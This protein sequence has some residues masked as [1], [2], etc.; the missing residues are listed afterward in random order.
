MSRPD[1]SRRRLVAASCAVAVCAA[2]A[3]ASTASGADLLPGITIPGL[4]TIPGTPTVPTPTTPAPP[5]IPA[6]PTETPIPGP[7]GLKAG[8]C[9]TRYVSARDLTAKQLPVSLTPAGALPNGAASDPV[10][11]RDSRANRY[12]AY[13]STATDIAVPVQAGRK[14]VYLAIRGGRVDPNANP[15]SLG[16]NQI[17][18][19]GP[20]G[21]AA[22]GDSWGAALSGTTGRNDKAIAARAMAFLSTATN[23]APG[24]NPTGTS[25][26]VRPVAG[27][28]I[29]RVKAPGV[30]TGVTV[31]GDSKVVWVTTDRGLFM[32]RDGK[33]RRIASGAGLSSPSTTVNG[34]QVAYERSGVV[35]TTT[36]EGR[37]RRIAVGS[38]PHADGGSADKGARA[39]MIRAIS[40]VR[41]GGAWRAETTGGPVLLKRFGTTQSLSSIN[42]GGNA[43]AFGN[44]AH[45]CIEV[46]LLDATQR[47]GGYSIPQG[48][49][50]SGQGTVTD[51]AVSTRY[52][53][54]AFTCSGGGLYLHYVGPK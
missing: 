19:V 3:G 47:R 1:R 28:A 50:P 43:V 33:V 41:D 38:H 12:L 26:F 40:F 46:R 54:L 39:G 31:S 4:P 15:W 14:N 9:A 11:S 49:C 45:A 24:G 18:S 42:G 22:D 44:G 20:G 10:F 53:Y 32:E 8:S 17:V 21:V 16:S 5:T 51:V 23:L 37:T 13:A 7:D 6:P 2:A 27:G 34:R 48:A 29:R 25:A 52:N 30:A 35:L 36:R